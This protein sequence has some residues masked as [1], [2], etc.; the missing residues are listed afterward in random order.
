MLLRSRFTRYSKDMLCFLHS[1]QHSEQ[2]LGRLDAMVS[3]TVG[4]C[5]SVW[6]V[7]MVVFS[8]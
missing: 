4:E 3:N 8:E 7:T 6:E 1:R 2:G 5:R